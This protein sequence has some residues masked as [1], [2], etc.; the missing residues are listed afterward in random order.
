MLGFALL[1]NI[2]TIAVLST[3]IPFRKFMEGPPN[4]LP[5]TFPFVWLPTFLVQAALF[6]HVLVFRAL[7]MRRRR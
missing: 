5:S 6:G 4:L 3:P 7:A 2:I 1:A